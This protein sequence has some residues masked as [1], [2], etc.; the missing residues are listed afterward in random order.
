MI[1]RQFRQLFDQLSSKTGINEYIDFDN[2]A[3]TSLPAINPL[4]VNFR[5][6]TRNKSY[7][8]E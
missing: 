4:M 6:E 8:N 7:G 1:D 3:V 5:Q 2:E